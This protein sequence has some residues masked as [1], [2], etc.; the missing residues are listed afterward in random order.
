[1]WS[2]LHVAYG[3]LNTSALI[4]MNTKDKQDNEH[5]EVNTGSE[6][7]LPPKPGHRKWIETG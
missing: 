3:I 5:V 6:R 7:W 2:D 1:M 4:F